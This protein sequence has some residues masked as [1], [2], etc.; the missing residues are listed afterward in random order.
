MYNAPDRIAWWMTLNPVKKQA[1]RCDNCFQVY[2]CI[3]TQRQKCYY[4]G[5]K[6]RKF[7]TLFTL[8]EKSYLC[9]FGCDFV[10]EDRFDLYKH[11]WDCHTDEQL[12]IWGINRQLFDLKKVSTENLPPEIFLAPNVQYI[13]DTVL[14]TRFGTTKPT[15]K[16][17]RLMSDVACARKLGLTKYIVLKI[18]SGSLNGT[19]INI[20]SEYKKI[21]LLKTADEEGGPLFRQY[22]TPHYM[23]YK[24]KK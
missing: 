8:D 3:Q 10:T 5:L 17:V 2:G 15:N 12:E 9:Q 6:D 16:T 7:A 14:M 22:F 13:I 20:D 23:T 19:P 11:F 21:H 24:E 1:T 18:C 4:V